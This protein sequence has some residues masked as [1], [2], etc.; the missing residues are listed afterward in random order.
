MTVWK[1]NINKY[2]FF[3]VSNEAEICKNSS[4]AEISRW[5][6]CGNKFSY[7]FYD[8]I[9]PLSNPSDLCGKRFNKKAELGTHISSMYTW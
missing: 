4:K 3:C 8:P 1:C 9:L 2:L 5:L 7:S 6:E